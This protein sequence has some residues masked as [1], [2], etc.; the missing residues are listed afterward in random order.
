ME[1]V[2]D[3]EQIWRFEP[4]EIVEAIASAAALELRVGGVL[5]R[6]VETDP[7]PGEWALIEVPWYPGRAIK[8][9]SPT[10]GWPMECHPADA[11]DDWRKI[12]E[13]P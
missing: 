3:A 8:L 13:C 1:L 12:N 6:K 11:H 10:F 9:G 7:Q 4:E 2:D 5:W